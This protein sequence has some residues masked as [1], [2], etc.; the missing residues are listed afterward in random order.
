MRSLVFKDRPNGRYWWY[1]NHH[2]VPPIFQILT[3]AEWECMAAWYDATDAVG[4][5]GGEAAIPCLSVLSGFLEGSS[6]RNIVQ[7]GHFQGFSTL[8]LGFMMRRMGYRHSIFSVDIDA[9]V[10]EFTETWVHRAGL[11]D[12]VKIVV[13]S[14]DAPHLPEIAKDY[15]G[16]QQIATMF[17]DSSHQHLHTLRELDLWW[18]HLQ[19]LG[20]I[21]MHDASVFATSFNPN[22]DP[23]V[24]RAL[25]EWTAAN[26]VSN[27]LINEQ[28]EP[29]E[30]TPL[31][32]MDGCG[33]A[34]L[35]KG[36]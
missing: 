15:L 27:L 4:S 30:Q 35:Q 28:V 36:K 20:L 5:T 6:V 23:G 31:A 14:S 33:L 17:I 7:L 19:P 29:N 8:L 26:S 12:Y 21:F 34:M 11:D 18:P 1:H 16:T 22:G 10:S 25:K 24:L 3:D 9:S 13:S 2:Y 32:Y